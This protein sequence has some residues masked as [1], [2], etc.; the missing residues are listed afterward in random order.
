MTDHP[1][2]QCSA[3]GL[4]RD[5]HMATDRQYHVTDPDGRQYTFCSACY[6]LYFACY[7]L[8]ADLEPCDSVDSEGGTAA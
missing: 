4:Y 7:G 1:R 8:S 6:L 3:A 2:V 5:H